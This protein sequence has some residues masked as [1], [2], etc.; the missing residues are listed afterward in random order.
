MAITVFHDSSLENYVVDVNTCLIL[1]GTVLSCSWNCILLALI[2]FSYL[3]Y[4]LS[5]GRKS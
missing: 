3:W 5:H 2:I 1:I 4:T